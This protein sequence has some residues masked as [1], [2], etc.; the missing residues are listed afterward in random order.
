M[1]AEMSV[2]ISK[3]NE[4]SGNVKMLNRFD[5]LQLVGSDKHDEALETID[6]NPAYSAMS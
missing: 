3:V 2:G 1:C 4:K 5:L 6:V